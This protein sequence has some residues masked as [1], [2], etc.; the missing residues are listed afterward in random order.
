MA[1]HVEVVKQAVKEYADLPLPDKGSVKKAI[2]GLETDPR[3]PQV[4]KLQDRDYYRLRVGDWRVFFAISDK[5]KKVTILSIER[6]TTTT[7]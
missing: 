4:K 6:R 7:Y 5:L 1:Y 2:L 3:G